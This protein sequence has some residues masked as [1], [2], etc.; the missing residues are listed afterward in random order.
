MIDI[1]FDIILI[2]AGSSAGR[3]DHTSNAINDLGRVI[4]HGIAI[5]PGHPVVLGIVGETPVIGIPGYPVSAALTTQLI[6]KPI[7]NKKLGIIESQEK[8]ITATTTKKIASSIGEDEFIRVNV[9]KIDNKFK[10]V[11]YKH[12]SP[13]DPR[14]S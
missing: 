14:Y 7:I 11:G 2:N 6:V 5:T 8:T 12:R 9:G 3:D 4:V 10:G 1:D 13:V